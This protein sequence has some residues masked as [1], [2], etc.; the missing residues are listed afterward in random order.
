MKWE[1]VKSLE[2]SEV[3][4]YHPDAV[5][6]LID[7]LDDVRVDHAELEND[8]RFCIAFWRDRSAFML[9]VQAYGE[10]LVYDPDDGWFAP[11]Q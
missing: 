2:V 1:S 11:P 9:T 8:A 5:V 4:R 7:V 3:G 6:D 10:T